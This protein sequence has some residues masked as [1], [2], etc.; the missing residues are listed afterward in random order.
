MLPRVLRPAE[1]VVVRLKPEDELR[2]VSV[3][4]EDAAGIPD[5]GHHHRVGI[6][7]VV[8]EEPGPAGG[9][10]PAYVDGILR[11]EWNAVQRTP[12]L[13]PHQRVLGF[14]RLVHG[15][16]VWRHY[17]V[18]LRIDALDAAQVRFHHLGRGDGLAADALG[19]LCSGC[20]D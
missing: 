19:Q 16:L 11:R 12:Q 7:D 2:D 14:A 15:G 3:S 4:Q 5:A 20:E 6:G 1:D 10:E 18:E 13:T 8:L 9:A 17:G